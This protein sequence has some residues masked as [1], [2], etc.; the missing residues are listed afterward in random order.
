M[1]LHHLPLLCDPHTREDL[2]LEGAVFEGDEIISGT[3]RSTSHSYPVIRGI[4]RFVNDEGYSDNFGYQWNRWARIQFEDQNVGGPMQ[5]HT[6][7]MF[8]HITQ[9]NAQKLRG[10]TVLDIGCGPGRFTDIALGM[11][12]SVVAIDYS[13]AIDAAR[14]NFS[15]KNTDV[16]FVQGDALLLPLKDNSMDY[17]F[18]IGVLH[19]TPSPASG[20]REAHRVTR[21]GGEFAIR[22]YTAAGFYTYPTVRFWRALF[23]G[24]RPSLGHYPPLAYSYVF[25]TLGFALGKAWRPLRYPL[26]AV[27]PTAWLPDYRWTIWDTFDAIATTHQS[28]HTPTEIA[29]WLHEAGFAAVRQI[30]GNDFVAQK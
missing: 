27:F 5:G 20:V 3:L 4:P 19:H 18:T 26:H 10:K 16:L 30:E 13:S 15:C 28:G 7:G 8:T 6:R 21:T 12:A 11:G 14:S 29:Q 1:K 22:V 2:T 25:G 23:L 24:L 17:S 9:F